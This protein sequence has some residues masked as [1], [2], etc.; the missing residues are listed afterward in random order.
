MELKFTTIGPEEAS[1]ILDAQ[2]TETNYRNLKSPAVKLYEHDMKKGRW[3]FNGDPIR[4]DRDG[5][6]IDGQHRLEAVRKSGIPQTFVVIEGLDPECAQTIDIGYKRSVEDYLRRMS[7]MY[8]TGCAAIVKQSLTLAKGNIT[9]GNSSAS[10]KISNTMIV[11]TFNG[12]CKHFTEAAE[13]GKEINKLSGKVIKPTE[14]GAI[15]YHLVYTLKYDIGKVRLFFDKLARV[16]R[17]DDSSIF[18]TT[19][20]ALDKHDGRSSRIPIL[21]KCWNS[22]VN[23][24]SKNLLSDDKCSNVFD[25]PDKKKIE[26]MVEVPIMI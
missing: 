10:Q 12:D 25:S 17:H 15:Y 14:A 5:N 1:K 22:F 21:I 8:M 26:K 20:N 13:F 24:N 4:F 23:G 11:D 6:L 16:T 18:K 3:M 19:Y 7:V 2:R 9:T